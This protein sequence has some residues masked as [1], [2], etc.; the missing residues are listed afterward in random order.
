MKRLVLHSIILLIFFP[1]WSQQ[2]PIQVELLKF[3]EA[4]ANEIAPYVY[5]NKLI[6][7]S[8]R[9]NEEGIITYTTS[10]GKTMTDYYVVPTVGGNRFEKPVI[11]A[12]ELNTHHFEG[13][14]TFDIE[15]D[16]F[17]F[18]QNIM[19]RDSKGNYLKEGNNMT[20]LYSTYVNG[21]FRNPQKFSRSV[22]KN[23]YNYMC[24]TID[25]E[26]NYLFFCSDEPGGYGGYDIYVCEGN[27]GRWGKPENLGSKVNTSG[28][29]IYPFA[30]ISG[31]L[32]FSSEK[33]PDSEGRFDVYYTYYYEGEW[34]TP[35]NAGEP[36]NSR[37]DDYG[38]YIHDDLKSGYFSSNRKRGSFDIYS[39]KINYPEFDECSEFEEASFC[40]RFFD[41]GG[42]SLDTLAFRYEWDLGDGTKV[43]AET[44]DHCYAEPGTYFVQLNLIDAVTGDL[45]INQSNYMVEVKD[46]HQVYI[47]SKD[48][49]HEGEE[50]V[51]DGLETNLE[52]FD[53][54][55]YYWFFGD[56]SKV[57]TSLNVSHIY[58]KEGVYNVKLGVTSKL[59]ERKQIK[60]ACGSKQIV[61]LKR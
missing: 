2:K 36:F 22:L 29:E 31:R 20:I 25:P 23:T 44:V 58:E 16:R 61:V 55:E 24:P 18:S 60:K 11:F 1:V 49:I 12:E 48:T 14:F 37:Y 4:G 38:V 33:L 21:E 57:V 10:D 59:D 3:N 28:D 30:H 5:Q 54:D 19:A 34:V 42:A 17:F 43:I 39:F 51:F 27:N 8:D 26:G 13:P 56:D 6:F 46:L 32:Y 52:D 7:C 15:R 41:Q 45:F 40:Y 35:T 47:N 9:K 53:V 50:I